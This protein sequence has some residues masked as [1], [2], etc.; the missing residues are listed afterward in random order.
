VSDVHYT[1]YIG[2]HLEY[3]ARFFAPQQM[4]QALRIAFQ[5]ALRPQ[6]LEALPVI[7]AVLAVEFDDR[8]MRSGHQGNCNAS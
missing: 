4:G 8:I 1:Q 2:Q 6:Q 7:F 5:Q 3:P